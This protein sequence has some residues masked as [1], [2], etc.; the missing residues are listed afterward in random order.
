MK[1]GEQISITP[2]YHEPIDLNRL[3]AA[4]LQLASELAARKKT[5]A[6]KNDGAGSDGEVPAVQPS[7]EDAA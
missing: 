1:E 3:V 6:A 2:A 7:D 4:A 5:V